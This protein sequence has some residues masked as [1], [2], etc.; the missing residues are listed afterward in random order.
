MSMTL[1]EI[2]PELR[3]MV[4]A[5]EIDEDALNSLSMAFEN[6]AHG[7]ACLNDEMQGWI[8]MAD[9]EVKRIQQQIKY[10]KNKKA[11]MIQYLQACME[12]AEL[13]KIETGTKTLA[14]QKTHRRLLL[15]TRQKFLPSF[16]DYPNNNTRQ[17]RCQGRY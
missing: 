7:I 3:E 11:R 10:A 9:A 17:E 12:T 4:M 14:L 6:K 16:Q 1:Y 15:K 8:D 2:A 5:D 13:S